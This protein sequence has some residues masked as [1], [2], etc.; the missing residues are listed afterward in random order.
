MK[1]ID[2]ENSIVSAMYNEEYLP[3][4]LPA[5]LINLGVNPGSKILSIKRIGDADPNNKTDVLIVLEDSENIKISAKLSNAHY[6]GN[7]Y[8]HERILKDFGNN[9]RILSKQISAATNWAND[10][11]LETPNNAPFVGVSVS[12]GERAGSTAEDFMNIY[13]TEDMITVAA[14]F[15][16]G[17]NVANC[18]YSSNNAPYNIYELLNNLMPITTESILGL[19][20]QF[21]VIYRPINPMTEKSNRGK[22]SYTIFVPYEKMPEKTI[23]TSASELRKIGKFVE[24]KPLGRIRNHNHILDFLDREYNIIIPKK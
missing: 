9:P 1:P 22:Q 7:W 24:I 20:G 18:L 4:E 8:T 12:F 14:G 13:S 2:L 3:N 15:G 11:L 17:D 19:T 6:F 10:W 23:I 5:W 21:K 16:D